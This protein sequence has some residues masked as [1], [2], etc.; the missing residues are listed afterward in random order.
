MQEDERV[1]RLSTPGT[2]STASDRVAAR[3]ARGMA[4]GPLGSRTAQRT[5]HS[6]RESLRR[7]S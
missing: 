2:R 4:A 3:N 1:R 6:T 7:Y 5:L